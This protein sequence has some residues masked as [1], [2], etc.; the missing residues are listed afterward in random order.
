SLDQHCRDFI[1]RSPFLL[2]A[3]TDGQGRVDISPKGDPAGFVQVL[4]DTTLAIPER[5][6][7][8]RADTFC[9]VLQHPHVGL[10]FLIPG[11]K[12]T[13]RVRGRARLVQDQALLDSMAEKGRSPV[14]ALVLDVEGAMFHCAK[15]IIR[16]ELWSSDLGELG[17][18]TLLAEAMADH[19]NG[20]IDTGKMQEIIVNDETSRLY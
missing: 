2:V 3:S 4:D 1:G 20:V 8:H 18:E 9:N 12:T 14:L 13:L 15:C 5:L 11:T 19:L 7:N 6:G 17:D 10:I 16:S